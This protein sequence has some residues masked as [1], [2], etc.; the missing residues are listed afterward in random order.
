M[1]KKKA[2]LQT[3]FGIVILNVAIA[4]GILVVVLVSVH[5]W[6]QH[7]TQHG[8]EVV[9]PNVTGMQYDEAQQCL[10]DS[11]LQ[12]VIIDSTFSNTVPLGTIVEQIPE[13][14]G[15][16]KKDRPVYAIINSS[17]HRQ[18]EIPDLHDISYRQAQ[19]TLR[20]LGISVG[21]VE[22]EPSEY[23]DIV[24]DLRYQG[25]PLI[26]G[27]KIN[28]G[29]SITMVVGKGKGTIK[30]KVPSLQGKS[31]TEARSLLINVAHLT[32]GLVQ[33]D[34]PP[35]VENMGDYII[36]RQSPT[37][38]TSVVEGTGVDV[39]LTLDIEKAITNS[40]D[41]PGEDDFF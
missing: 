30:V 27:E 21:K 5:L 36:Y 9:V 14:G 31:L 29:T 20:S 32:L 34:E 1:T 3:R 15:F 26:P 33:Y 12:L 41:D 40:S 2:F 6:L 11:C 8:I 13:A 4:V 24:L 23:R 19:A 16:A 39:N 38:G 22:Y 28:E 17:Y 10:A 35:V 18:V 25:R 37:P 7:Y